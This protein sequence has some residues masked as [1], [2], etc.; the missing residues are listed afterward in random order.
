MSRRIRGLASLAG[1]ASAV[2]H[3]RA[4]HAP[5]DLIVIGGPIYTADAGR[6]VDALAVRDGRFVRWARA[7]TCWR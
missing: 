6:R 4:H 3:R 1:L 5:A 7:P 2:G